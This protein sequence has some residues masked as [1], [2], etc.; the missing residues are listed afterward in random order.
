M[1]IDEPSLR[2][3]IARNAP[4]ILGFRVVAYHTLTAG[5]TTISKT[6]EL[7]PRCYWAIGSVFQEAGLPDGCLNVL[8]HR[9]QDAAA[10]TT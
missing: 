9:T 3:V 1:Q 4:S 5:N 6:S 8:A 2:A 10:I 7:S